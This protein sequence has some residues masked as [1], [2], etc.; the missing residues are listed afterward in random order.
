VIHQ[1]T[2]TELAARLGKEPVYLLD[3]R[4]P[5]EHET[6]SLP[7]SALIPLN[8]L[9]AR[10]AEVQPPDGSLLVAYCHHGVR[11]LTA[12]HVLQRNGFTNVASLAGGIDAWSLE[13][14][15]SVPRY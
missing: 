11:S 6:A 7:G 4:Q 3:V 5:W 12:A 10:L 2:P 15:P 1:I 9:D 13:V 8:E 14:D